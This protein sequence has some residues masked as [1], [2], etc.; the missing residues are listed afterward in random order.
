MEPK[1]FILEIP[2]NT[3]D[4][5]RSQ[6]DSFVD[7]MRKQIFWGPQDQVSYSKLHRSTNLPADER[8]LNQ[9]QSSDFEL[10]I[11]NLIRRSNVSQTNV[12]LIK[13]SSGLDELRITDETE[14]FNFLTCHTSD[15]FW[16]IAELFQRPYQPFVWLVLGI[17]LFMSGIV[18][19]IVKKFKKF[20]FSV[21]RLAMHILFNVIEIGIHP[22]NIRGRK[23]IFSMLFTTWFLMSIVLTN[24]YKG[25]IISYLS[26]PWAPKQEHFYFAEM[27]GFTFYS[28]VAPVDEEWYWTITATERSSLEGNKSRHETQNFATPFARLSR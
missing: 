1:S 9:N 14:G 17:T 18:V 15:N 28:R 22:G 3:S 2:E 11:L 16:S 6:M 4:S 12:N 27:K 20:E 23:V 10:F 25:L 5:M 21:S 13:R 8:Y 7:K 24:S 26:A 19:V